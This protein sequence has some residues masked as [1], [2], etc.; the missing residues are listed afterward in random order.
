MAG[1][2]RLAPWI[3]AGGDH[4][5]RGCWPFHLRVGR[6]P[7]P[8]AARA[9]VDAQRRRVDV[10]EAKRERPRSAGRDLG[11]RLDRDS[12]EQELRSDGQRVHAVV[13][14]ERQRALHVFHVDPL[15]VD[16]QHHEPQQRY[17]PE[18]VREAQ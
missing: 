10:D 16:A 9:E 2:F 14:G 6:Q 5:Q 13:V 17:P 7:D 15:V 4:D 3:A 11:Q 8:E 1:R 12:G 18:G